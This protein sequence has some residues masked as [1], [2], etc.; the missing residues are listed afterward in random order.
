MIAFYNNIP[1]GHI[2]AGMRTYNVHEPFPEEINRA[3]TTLLSTWHFAPTVKQKENLLRERIAESQI[4][5]TGNP[6]ID[7]LYWVLANTSAPKFFQQWPRL[8]V[9]TAHRRENIGDSMRS[10][11]QA[12]IN[13]SNRFNDIHFVLPVHPNPNVQQDIFSLLSK[14]ERIHLLEPLR[15]DEF[16]HL[17]AKS[18][19]VLTDSGGVQEEAPALNKPVIVLRN[20]TERPA[21]IDCGVGLL[22]GTETENIVAT[23]TH[24]LSDANAFQSMVK[25]VSPYGDGH[26]AERIIA[27]LERDLMSN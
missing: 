16:A 20:T 27:C 2:E 13:L 12:I 21:V 9:V 23:V 22:V 5:V 8:I 4:F 15:Y 11:C 6:V 14:Y 1:F 26:A 24:L 25:G 3:L 17:M 7:S 18:I 10:I 19:L